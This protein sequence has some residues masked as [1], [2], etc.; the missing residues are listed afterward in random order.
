MI[1]ISER[2]NGLFKSVGKAIDAR[3]KKFIQ[4][5]ALDQVKAGANMLDVNTGPGVDRPEEIMKWLV[6][7]IQEVTPVQL[8]IDAPVPSVIEA[9]LEVCKGRALINSTT[10]EAKKMAAIFPLAKMY[11]SE[12]ICLTLDEK[13]IPND[14]N[15]RCELALTMITNA[16][17]FEITPDRIFL[18]PLALPV[19]AAQDQGMKVLESL[20]QFKTLCDPAPKTT[21]G[22]SNVSNGTKERPLINRTFLTM[23]M[24]YGLDSAIMN[25]SDL[26]LM[27]AVRT[28][29]ILLNQKLY[30]D[31][32]LRAC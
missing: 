2:V 29:E 6:T 31:S 19:G 1:V 12:I 17:E 8:S 14:A 16:M 24:A 4:A 32:Y 3:D 26:D 27:N 9:G 30:C 15:S 23:L 22:L 20:K 18:D 21:I 10:A 28:S 25:P 13:G 5:L 7:T 11:D